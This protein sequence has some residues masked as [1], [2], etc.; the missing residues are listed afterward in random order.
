MH[1]LYFTLPPT[2]NCDIQHS[3][4]SQLQIAQSGKSIKLHNFNLL[5][6]LKCKS[7][8]F[9]EGIDW[10]GPKVQITG[11]EMLESLIVFIEI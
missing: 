6:L 11:S 1:A 9:R 4:K 3:S 5:L 8:L 7:E 2:D 10:K